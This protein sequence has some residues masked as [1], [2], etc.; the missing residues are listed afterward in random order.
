MALM[1]SQ[2]RKYRILI[3]IVVPIVCAY[4]VVF[5]LGSAY[6][7]FHNLIGFFGLLPFSG[8]PDKSEERNRDFDCSDIYIFWNSAWFALQRTIL[9]EDAQAV[10]RDKK[11]QASE[12]EAVYCTGF[13]LYTERAQGTLPPR[14]WKMFFYEFRALIPFIDHTTYH[15][16]YWYARNDF[17]EAVV[18][19]TTTGVIA[20]SA[21][22]GG[23]SRFISAQ[24]N[25]WCNFCASDALVPST[26]RK[27]VGINSS[28]FTVMQ[29]VS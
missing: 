24:S 17:P 10:I 16:Q 28:I 22:W 13:H 26:A 15:P 8:N 21:I 18:P 12:F 19:P 3:F 5:S 25:K 29:C 23:E 1:F 11:I 27:M 6:R 4:E 14:D 9:L 20:D 7:S 2:Y